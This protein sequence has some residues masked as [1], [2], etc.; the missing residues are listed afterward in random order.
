VAGHAHEPAGG[1]EARLD[2]T[3]LVAVCAH[4][5]PEGLALGALLLGGGVGRARAVAAVAAVETTTLAGGLV[6]VVALRE[7]SPVWVA[8]VL[9]HAGGGF[10]YLAAHALL[11]ELLKHGKTIVLGGFAAGVA[12]IGLL[13]VVVRML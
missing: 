6:G 13:E 10:L 7:A 4:K 11:G 12:L 2:W 5:M 1:G 9:A 8:A 3:L